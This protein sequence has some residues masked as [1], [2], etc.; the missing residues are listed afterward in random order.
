[1]GQSNTREN[2]INAINEHKGKHTYQGKPY[3]VNPWNDNMKN[4]EK[5]PRTTT[6]CSNTTIS[7]L[8]FFNGL[9]G[10]NL[11]NLF[12]SDGSVIFSV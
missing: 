11:I 2:E 4:A 9:V 6:Q 8:I 5:F 12:S 10:K 3:G 1:M 7:N